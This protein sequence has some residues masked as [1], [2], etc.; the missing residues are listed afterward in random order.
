MLIM[1]SGHTPEEALIEAMKAAG[2]GMT[3]V[4][5][6]YSGTYEPQAVINT[7]EHDEKIFNDAVDMCIQKL[8]IVNCM[9]DRNEV[10]AE[11]AAVLRALKGADREIELSELPNECSYKLWRTAYDRGYQQGEAD[12]IAKVKD[13]AAE[14]V[15]MSDADWN[16]FKSEIEKLT[17]QKG[18]TE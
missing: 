18:G 3:I 17:E 15:S 16:W 1:R 5:S 11:A 4:N 6:P 8:G 12:G 14:C 7:N 13:K 10:L 2:I 9:G